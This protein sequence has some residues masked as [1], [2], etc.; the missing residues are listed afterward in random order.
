MAIKKSVW[1][2]ILKVAVAAVTIIAGVL[3]LGVMGYLFYMLFKG[4]KT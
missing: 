3:A 1:S 2:M 4:D